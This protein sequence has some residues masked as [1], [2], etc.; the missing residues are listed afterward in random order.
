MQSLTKKMLPCSVCAMSF[1]KGNWN[2]KQCLNWKCPGW[3]QNPQNVKGAGLSN[4]LFS[5]ALQMD[6][7]LNVKEVHCKWNEGVRWMLPLNH[8]CFFPLS[9]VIAHSCF[10]LSE[11]VRDIFSQTTV[12]HHIPFNWDC[13]FIRLHFGHERNKNLSYTEFTQ[14]LQVYVLTKPSWWAAW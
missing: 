11:D 1:H 7:F 6:F 9:L 12:H 13:E 5:F 8:A 10:T 2:W 3:T 14:F 4:S